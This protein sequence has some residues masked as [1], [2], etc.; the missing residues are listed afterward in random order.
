MR[1]VNDEKIVVEFISDLF[2]QLELEDIR[3]TIPG[4]FPG[5]I[6]IEWMLL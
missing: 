3:I 5:L 1:I 4:F 6:K 2:T